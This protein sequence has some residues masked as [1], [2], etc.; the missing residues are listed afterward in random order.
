MS[1][2]NKSRGNQSATLISRT[3][4]GVALL[5]F[6]AYVTGMDYLNI[7]TALE[8]TEHF[9][10]GLTLLTAMPKS[11]QLTFTGQGDMIGWVCGVAKRHRLDHEDL[12]VTMAYM[13]EQRMLKAVDLGLDGLYMVGIPDTF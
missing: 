12:M 6:V 4:I 13:L 7:I 3:E 2:S 1:Q 8:G 11:G 10:R 5:V 9:D